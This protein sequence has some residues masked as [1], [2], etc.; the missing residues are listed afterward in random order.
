MYDPGM[1]LPQY[2]LKDFVG[3]LNTADG[4]FNLAPNEAQD[5]MNV[6]LS[7]RGALEQRAGRTRW[8]ASGF[9]TDTGFRVAQH[10]RN[11]YF[12]S[13]RLLFASID[14][15][16][17]SFDTAGAGT[18]LFN[19]TPGAT[20][21]FEQMTD[22]AGTNFLWAGNGVDEA[23]RIS[24]ALAVTNWTDATSTDNATVNTQFMRVWKN[25][26]VILNVNEPQRLRFSDIANPESF[27]DNNFQDIRASE[28]DL[29]PI[30]WMELLGDVLVVFKRR[31]VWA[32]TGDVPNLVARRIGDP[33][34]EG[35]F[36]SC[37]SEGRV[38]YWSRNGIWSTDGIQPPWF[39]TRK[40][41][42]YVAD[43]ANTLRHGEV[44]L[45]AA[46]DRRVLAAFTTMDEVF[47]NRVIEL[48]TGFS[49]D[50]RD[51]VAEVR[52]PITL[53]DFPVASMCTFRDSTDQDI[54]VAGHS[55]DQKLIQLFD[56]L[57]DEGVA[58]S[59]RWKSAWLPIQEQ[60]PY[61]RLRRVN[62]L[63]AGDAVLN[64]YK[65]FQDGVSFTGALDT[66]VASDPLWGGGIWDGG[67]W[68]PAPA[69]A[70]ATLRPESR[71][72]YH[73]V[74]ITNSELNQTF[75][76]LAIE[77]RFRGGTEH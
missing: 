64:I 36:E 15:D 39:E 60:E 42:N 30:T 2:E 68:D 61:E 73:C 22:A 14:G 49:I 7:Q 12:A 44:R 38:Y 47:N 59:S 28:D 46:R 50:D 32:L 25:R 76:V 77:F 48:M 18:L 24:T 11:W 45:F 71:G 35:R 29:D 13:T 26:M 17:Y 55:D 69:T 16:I 62:V 19:G 67:T 65:D 34:C 10:L 66:G 70:L 5:L 37:V 8:D 20:W 4:P 75:T 33:G 41:E 58:I 74:E 23:K 72:R 1:A 51:E 56:G 63:G 31:S 21:C 54:I 52:A 6:T 40:I 3:G 9:P 53:H 43:N 57:N 27:P